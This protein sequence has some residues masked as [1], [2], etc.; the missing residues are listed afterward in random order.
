[1][2][3]SFKLR[4]SFRPVRTKVSLRNLKLIEDF[5]ELNTPDVTLK[6]SPIIISFVGLITS[7]Y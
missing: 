6:K 1:M 2:V 5:Y 4:S 3:N 7:D